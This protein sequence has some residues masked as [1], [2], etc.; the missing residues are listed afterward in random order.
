LG[1]HYIKQSLTA[2]S[3][4]LLASVLS[5]SDMA[6]RAFEIIN[7]FEEMRIRVCVKGGRGGWVEL[8]DL[9]FSM[10]T[11]EGDEMVEIVHYGGAVEGVLGF[12][13]HVD[14]LLQLRILNRLLSLAKAHEVNK[15]ALC[16]AGV[17]VKILKEVLPSADTLEILD[18]ACE[19]IKVLG[20]HSVS[21]AD[22]KLMLSMLG[23]RDK[24]DGK[25]GRRRGSLLERK[26]SSVLV[27][28]HSL[29]PYYDALLD[30]IL[31]LAKGK[32]RD[33]DLFL[34]PGEQSGISLPCLE[35][36]PP[37]TGYT[38][39]TWFKVDPLPMIPSPTGSPNS[40]RLHAFESHEPEKTHPRLFSMLTASGNGFEVYFVDGA[41]HVSFIKQGHASNFIVPE[42]N[43]H[44]NQW[45]FFALAQQKPRT[46]FGHAS[47]VEIFI[48]DEVK[49]RFKADYPSDSDEYICCCI[50]A[51]V[52]GRKRITP[53]L[54]SLSKIGFSRKIRGRRESVDIRLPEPLVHQPDE[55]E[56]EDGVLHDCFAGQMTSIY[57][58]NDALTASTLGGIYSLGPS[59]GSQFRPEDMSQ[60]SSEETKILFEGF[61]GNKLWLQYH[62]RAIDGALCVDVAAKESG[63]R[64]DGRLRETRVCSAKSFRTAI[65][66]LGGVEVLFP[67]IF[68]CDLVNQGNLT[69]SSPQEASNNNN[70]N[71]NNTNNKC[72]LFFEILNALISGDIQTQM[73]FAASRNVKVI[74]N[75]LL[76]NVNPRNFNMALLNVLMKLSKTATAVTPLIY[77]IYDNLIFNLSLWSLAS[78]AN[79]KEYVTFVTQFLDGHQ[80]LTRSRYGIIFLLDTI[81]QYYWIK[82][83]ENLNTLDKSSSNLAGQQGRDFV[84]LLRRPILETIGGYLRMG[85]TN[86][87]FARI[88][89]SLF[90]CNDG[91]HISELLSVIL[92][93]AMQ[94]PNVNILDQLLT[95]GGI[96]LPFELLKRPE[97]SV[98]TICL[99]FM[100]QAICSDKVSDRWTKRLRMDDVG[101]HS[102]AVYVRLLGIN[103]LEESVSKALLALSLEEI[104]PDIDK[105]MLSTD[106]ISP[107]LLPM[108]QLRN[109][110]PLA[111]LLELLC[112][113]SETI[114]SKLD[115]NLRH[116]IR[117]LQELVILFTSKPENCALF[118]KISG[119]QQLL[120]QLVPADLVSV[121]PAIPDTPNL[122]SPPSE[123][124]DDAL[125]SSSAGLRI[126]MAS[127][128][129]DFE[130]SQISPITKNLVLENESVSPIHVASS[131]PSSEKTKY[132]KAV[133]LSD[134][135]IHLRNL[136]LEV[137]V[138][139]LVDSF[140]VDKRSWRLVEEATIYAWLSKRA[141]STELIR[142]LFSKL[143]QHV[144]KETLSGL[145]SLSN[146]KQVQKSERFF[147]P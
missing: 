125:I 36:W 68:H 140:N 117:I 61:L 91:K 103:P 2:E 10:M 44:P 141:D 82:A 5:G 55:S 78:L 133:I 121:E 138:V 60:Y 116:A 15:V 39:F 7:G 80:K 100:T 122:E 73:D 31:T 99:Y 126:S 84:H 32:D 104:P 95:A 37:S 142:H 21:V 139:L 11:V 63:F 28:K 118:R 147:F 9:I 144:M 114:N 19:I 62:P 41:I 8:I 16:R 131:T 96:E 107:Q 145:K 64:F 86:E 110:S 51:R 56:E 20:E 127:P 123:V 33:L 4:K 23:H 113:Q 92:S 29:P 58:M 146:T 46:P 109:P 40:I 24:V 129:K 79:Q 83:P 26:G 35:K 69:C 120:L 18:C 76:Q 97:S 66:V 132:F 119:W 89:Q 13:R 102:A 87:E 49:H 65:R 77:D 71:N 3:I 98:R 50:G 6:R 105:Y 112:R 101:Y 94:A 93:S 136:V 75:L 14:T 54:E 27:G 1:S 124:K 30:C 72:L 85:A 111:A 70:S 88:A 17:I 57:L 52:M 130:T 108:H 74:G 137:V 43:I 38:L 25:P 143:L 34:F 90:I 135:A 106:P 45:Y 22:V 47:D 48:N 53:V 42:F 128:M 134:D 115:S 12:Y 67:L 81:E 59:H